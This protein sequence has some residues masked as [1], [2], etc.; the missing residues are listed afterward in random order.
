MKKNRRARASRLLTIPLAVALMAPIA[1]CN[2]HNDEMVLDLSWPSSFYAQGFPTDLRNDN[3]HIRVG[4]FPRPLHLFTLTY[5]NQIANSNFGYSPAMPLYMQFGSSFQTSAALT[6]L[7]ATDFASAQSPVQVIDIDPE[8]P[9]YGQRFP[10]QISVTHAADTYRPANLLQVRPVGK[11]LREN[12]TYALITTKNFAAN[13]GT[14]QP[15]RILQALLS[16]KNPWILN[17]LTLPADAARAQKVYA[18]LHQFL[19]SNGVNSADIIGAT[20]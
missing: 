10:L 17:P 1:A 3:G 7:S 18:P 9:D 4:D 8:T 6:S 14:T 2:A 12:T 5:K 13:A 15:N 20:V 11:P 19:T 16:G